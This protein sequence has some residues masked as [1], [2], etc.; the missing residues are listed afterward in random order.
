MTDL[1]QPYTPDMTAPDYD[2]FTSPVDARHAL[3]VVKALEA[4][5]ADLQEIWRRHLGWES[6]FPLLE[7]GA[8]EDLVGGIQD[9]IKETKARIQ[10]FD[11]AMQ[12]LWR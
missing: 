5:E 9:Q 2:G 11:D 7:P 1:S 3:D 12:G 6:D 8:F 4:D 10:D